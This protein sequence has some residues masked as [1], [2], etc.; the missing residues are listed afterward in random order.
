M[1]YGPNT[2]SNEVANGKSPYRS[3]EHSPTASF[4]TPA[5]SDRDESPYRPVMQVNTNTKTISHKL[6]LMMRAHQLKM[7]TVVKE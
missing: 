6:K 7:D 5:V 1:G 4:R 2:L 3:P